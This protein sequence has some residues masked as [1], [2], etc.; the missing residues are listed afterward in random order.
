MQSFSHLLSHKQYDHTNV[1]T[2][3]T[4]KGRLGTN[5]MKANKHL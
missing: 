1:F 5:A 4:I 2:A 3:P